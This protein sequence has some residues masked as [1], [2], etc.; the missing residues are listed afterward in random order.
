[1]DHVTLLGAEAVE[2]AGHIIRGAADDFTVQ[3]AALHDSLA[4]LIERLEELDM[5]AQERLERAEKMVSEAYSLS[6]GKHRE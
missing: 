4:R 1:M 3:V 2:K 5:R 6:D